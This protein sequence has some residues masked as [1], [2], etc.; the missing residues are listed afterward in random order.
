M[1]HA[2]ATAPERATESAIV[3]KDIQEKIA[4][5]APMASM[6]HLKMKQSCFAHSA[7]LAAP[8]HAPVPARR[9]ATNAR[10]VGSWRRTTKGASTSTSVL[11]LKRV[12]RRTSSAWTTKDRIRVSNATSPALAVM[13]TD[14]ICV[15]N[16][17]MDM[18]YVKEFAPVS[19]N[20]LSL[21][22]FL[23]VLSYGCGFDVDLELVELSVNQVSSVGWTKYQTRCRNWNLY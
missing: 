14:L 21:I 23:S 4:N 13:E 5:R 2:K 15:R 8:T 20:F 12:P 6:K 17:P 11:T 22:V 16:V 10:R 1:E 9:T 19:N 7:T 3:I 18:N